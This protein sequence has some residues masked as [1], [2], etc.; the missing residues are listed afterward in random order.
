MNFKNLRVRAGMTQ[1]YLAS[2]LGVSRSTIAK[3][4]SGQSKPRAGVLIK[5]S[6]I[7]NCT[8]DELLENE[9][10]PTGSQA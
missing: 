3:W 8:I 5:L 1:C 9:K 2:L 6:H 10:T 7:L 4:E